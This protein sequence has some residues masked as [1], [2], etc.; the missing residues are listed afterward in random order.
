MRMRETRTERASE[1]YVRNPKDPGG[2]DRLCKQDIEDF[3]QEQLINDWLKREGAAGAVEFKYINRKGAARNTIDQRSVRLDWQV[4]DE[5]GSGTYADFIAGSDG[6]DLE[7]RLDFERGLES[8]EKSA[9][10]LLDEKIEEFCEILNLT[11]SAEWIKK[12][13]RESQNLEKLRSS[14]K[15][16]SPLE[17]STISLVSLRPFLNFKE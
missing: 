12:S 11:G 10:D 17:I 14:M 13:L 9:A 1:P 2:H 3:E 15:E 6:R 16:E 5:K 7:C 4:R 8:P